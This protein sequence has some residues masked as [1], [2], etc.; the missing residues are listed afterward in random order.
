MSVALVLDAT[1]VANAFATS[2]IE[3]AAMT[4]LI[5][6]HL[7]TLAEEIELIWKSSFS[8]VKILFLINRY[9][10][11]GVMLVQT[12]SMAGY[13]TGLNDHVCR[14]LFFAVSTWQLIAGG[15]ISPF[16]LFLRVW[17][18]YGR[19]RTVQVVVG[20][21]CAANFI[22]ILISATLNIWILLGNIY[23]APQIN[24]CVCTQRPEYVWVIW[25][26]PLIYETVIFGMIAYKTWT[27]MREDIQTPIITALWQD[28]ILYFTVLVAVRLYT[29]L[30]WIVAP[31]SL[32]FMGI[33]LM[34]ATITTMASRTILHLRAAARQRDSGY[35]TPSWVAEE[36]GL[37]PMSEWLGLRV[38][39][40]TDGINVV[41]GDA[42][43]RGAMSIQ[44]GNLVH[45]RSTSTLRRDVVSVRRETEVV[46]D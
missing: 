3:A 4:A 16:L 10:V 12:W 32:F 38:I 7:L 26:T 28:G 41:D 37:P 2:Y 1:D 11:L 27:H 20:G 36:S 42:V 31:P 44:A 23:Y 8:L 40:W 39:T 9:S 33:Y 18:I 17:S 19:T 34:L 5:Y 29:I 13:A 30:A 35:I 6:D 43:A 46:R 14:N 25:V 45:S 22:A 21:L 15:G 24:R